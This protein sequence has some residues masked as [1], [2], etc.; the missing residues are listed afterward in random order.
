M[1]K[2]GWGAGWAPGRSPRPLFVVLGSVRFSDT[3]SQGARGVV[4][5]TPR[6]PQTSHDRKEINFA[7]PNVRSFR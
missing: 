6:I 5:T 1:E 3:L 4:K 7:P 2:K